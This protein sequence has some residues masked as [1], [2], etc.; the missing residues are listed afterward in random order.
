MNWVLV[1][2]LWFNQF[3]WPHRRATNTT[4]ELKGR[5]TLL[6]QF[7]YYYWMT[8]CVLWTFCC[9]QR[10]GR[11]LKGN[12]VSEAQPRWQSQQC[13]CRNLLPNSW[14]FFTCMRT[15]TSSSLE[16]RGHHTTIRFILFSQGYGKIR[17]NKTS[18]CLGV[19]WHVE[20]FKKTLKTSCSLIFTKKK[21][22]SFICFILGHLDN[23]QFL[24]IPRS[25]WRN[26]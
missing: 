9:N 3:S 22:F 1:M 7:S 4:R 24:D 14:E 6:L 2:G 12:C 11:A 25:S 18:T 20:A 15:Y 17:D 13:C 26:P 5:G 23:L 21:S 16:Q 19:A 10:D 8:D